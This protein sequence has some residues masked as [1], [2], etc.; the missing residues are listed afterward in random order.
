[1]SNMEYSFDGL[2]CGISDFKLNKL[3]S[4]LTLLHSET[5]KWSKF[6]NE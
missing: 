1:M 2:G 6:D 5:A 3:E 4:S